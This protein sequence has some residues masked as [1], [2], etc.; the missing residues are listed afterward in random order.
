MSDVRCPGCAHEGCQ[1]HD[2]SWPDGCSCC[3]VS[4]CK[5]EAS[6]GAGVHSYACPNAP[7]YR[8]ELKI[9]HEAR[10]AAEGERDAMRE[11]L[12]KVATEWESLSDADQF[13]RSSDVLLMCAREVRALAG[14]QS[15]PRPEQLV[16]ALHD[17]VHEEVGTSRPARVGSS[18]DGFHAAIRAM[19]KPECPASRDNVLCTCDCVPGEEKP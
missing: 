1:A 19:H 4:V 9:E 15:Q 12:L 17:R 13:S 6:Y 3:T 5:C 10:L 8:P 16:G 11:S 14:G 18:W 7:G 2:P